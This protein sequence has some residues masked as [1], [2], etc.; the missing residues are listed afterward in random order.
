MSD[1]V[2]IKAEEA[3][4]DLGVSVA[5]AYKLIKKMNGELKAKGFITI[6]GRVSRKYYLEKLYGAEAK[7]GEQNAGLQG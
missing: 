5:Y 2:F 7:K 1:T 3:A 6:S 4:R